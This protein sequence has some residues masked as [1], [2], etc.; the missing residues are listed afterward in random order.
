M[1]GIEISTQQARSLQILSL[2]L[3]QPCTIPA[4][5]QDI[6]P[7]IRRMGVLQLDTIHIVARSHYFVLWS[8]LGAYQPE[9]LDELLAE[10]E[11]YEYWAH[12]ACLLPIEDYPF[13]KW[14]MKEAAVKNKD[15][16]SWFS[17]NSTLIDSVR[18]Q[19][20]ERGPVR[21]ADFIPESQEPGAWWNWKVEKT[22]LEVLYDQGELMIARRDKFQRVYELASRL[23]PNLINIIEPNT[24][25]ALT[26]L[27]ER[28]VKILGI[29]QPRWV[30]DYYR[31]PKKETLAILDQLIR[32][33]IVLPVT[34][35]NW[36]SPGIIH[37]DNLHLLHQIQHGSTQPAGTSLLS[38]FDPLVWDRTRLQG[39]F[40]MDFKVECYT[41]SEKR[42]YGYWLLPVLHEDHFAGRVDIK[43][44]RQRKVLEMR[45]IFLEPDMKLSTTFMDGLA[46]AI[47]NCSI[48]HQL[49]TVEIGSCE[50]I[51]LREGLEV[52]LK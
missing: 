17:R 34:V 36:S 28:T 3:G 2:G 23:H 52:R 7:T 47:R 22:A 10:K 18:Y 5:K 9:W 20:Q 37:P 41:M 21:S 49:E 24:E 45:G 1:H 50:N 33:G 29:C 38:P 39:L 25:T 4:Q 35:E 14:R 16:K 44:N 8:R 40:G 48:W 30:A 12:A 42:K 32:K 11:L 46:G 6:L 27:I 26:S 13:L 19:V 15:P 51:D 31:L 43:A